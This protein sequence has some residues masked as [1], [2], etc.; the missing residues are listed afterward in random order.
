MLLVCQSLSCVQL[1]WD[2][3]DCSPPGC[4]VHK[5]SQA[6]RLEWVAISFSRESSQM[7]DQTHVFCIGSWIL[8]HW[9][10][11]EASICMRSLGNPD[12]LTLE[13]I[14]C[15]VAQSCLT[16]LLCPWNSPGRNTGVGCHALFHGIF[17]TQGSNPGIPHCRWILY[18]LSHQGSPSLSCSPVKSNHQIENQS[19]VCDGNSLSSFLF[20]HWGIKTFL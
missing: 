4:S 2:P 15:L 3:M 10:T 20:I 6:R 1:F 13:F 16:L 12:R 5:I 18:H 11:G 14:L 9:V 19:C 7:R 17:P 8:S